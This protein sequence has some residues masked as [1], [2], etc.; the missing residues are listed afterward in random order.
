MRISLDR[1]RFLPAIAVVGLFLYVFDAPAYAQ[2]TPV[3]AYTSMENDQLG[4]FKQ[5][6]EKAV[7]EADVQWVRDSTGVM[8]ARLLAEKANPKADIV[9]G[10]AA[11]S[12]V[13]LGKQGLGLIA[14]RQAA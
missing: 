14:K 9:L 7:P 8:T 3:V 12:I 13:Q 10:L 11:S 2:K 4:V 6:I 5:A 1:G